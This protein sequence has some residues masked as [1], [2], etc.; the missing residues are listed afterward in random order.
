MDTEQTKINTDA[1]NTVAVVEFDNIKARIIAAATTVEAITIY[2]TDLMF[3]FEGF[4]DAQ[5]RKSNTY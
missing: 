3:N 1:S 2:P 4:D 5:V